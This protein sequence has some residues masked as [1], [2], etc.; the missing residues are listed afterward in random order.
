MTGATRNKRNVWTVNPK[1][2][3]GA[4]FATWPEALVEPMIKAGSSEHGCCS[5]CRAP[6]R[7]VLEVVETISTKWGTNNQETRDARL[8]TMTGGMSND[9]G[10]TMKIKKTV[11]WEA[12]CKCEDAEVVHCRVL[13]PFSGSATTGAVAMR[14]GRDYVGTDLQ[15]DYLDL[16]EARLQGRKAP[17]KKSEADDGPDLIGELFG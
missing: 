3:P 15:P 2:Y 5:K 6:Y 13:D 10:A 14:F 4:H 1:P 8:A 11:G 12:T 16:A 7:R 17:S 9:M